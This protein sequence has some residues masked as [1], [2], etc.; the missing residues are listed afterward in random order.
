MRS[1]GALFNCRSLTGYRKRPPG[2]RDAPFWGEP[3]HG[4]SSS[5]VTPRRHSIRPG[6][7][8]ADCS[9][10]SQQPRVVLPAGTQTPD[11]DGQAHLRPDGQSLASWQRW[12]RSALPPG[13]PRWPYPSPGSACALTQKWCLQ[14]SGVRGLSERWQGLARLPFYFTD[15]AW[16]GHPAPRPGRHTGPEPV[17]PPGWHSPAPQA[18]RCFLWRH[19]E[20]SR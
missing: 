10:G 8:L 17:D 5:A 9:A 13:S 1:L 11:R 16:L 14:A 19:P 15:P 2:P 7:D 4:R 3:A 12:Q 18:P 6:F 20:H